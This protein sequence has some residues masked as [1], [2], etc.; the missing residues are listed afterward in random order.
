[1]SVLAEREYPFRARLIRERAGLDAA[2]DRTIRRRLHV[3]ADAGWLDH[4][5]GSKWWYPGPHAEA[6]FHT[7][8]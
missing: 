2:Q 5:E 7:D 3:M 1:M 4:T 6:R 8:H